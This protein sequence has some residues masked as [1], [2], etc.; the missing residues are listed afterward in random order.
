M[1][2]MLMPAWRGRPGSSRPRLGSSRLPSVVW[3][4]DV[5]ES[6]QREG[7]QGRE[8]GRVGHRCESTHERPLSAPMGGNRQV[9]SHIEQR[10]SKIQLP[11]RR[12][13]ERRE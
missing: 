11:E 8:S 9:P 4:I 5:D 2:I 1:M 7:E 6:D 10:R 12:I 13:Q 3:R